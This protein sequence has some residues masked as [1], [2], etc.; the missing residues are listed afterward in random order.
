MKLAS[1][2]MASSA[3]ISKSALPSD[4]STVS[5]ATSLKSAGVTEFSDK[6]VAAHD[7]SAQLAP[8]KMHP[9]NAYTNDDFFGTEGK[10]HLYA[11]GGYDRLVGNGG[12]DYLFAGDNNGDWRGTGNESGRAAILEG[13]ADN[14]LMQVWADKG[15]FFLDTGDGRDHVLISNDASYVK[16]NNYDSTDAGDTFEFNATFSGKA[17]IWSFDENDTLMFN[18]VNSG[19]GPG[20]HWDISY[21]AQTYDTTFFNPATQG[22]IVLHGV[23]ADRFDTAVHFGPTDQL[24]YGGWMYY[25]EFPM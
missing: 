6:A 21:D 18:T 14:D 25:I 16:I 2:K 8:T 4:H 12:D 11:D 13:G 20:T 22:E 1:T 5:T 15:A 19:S 9:I 23:E 24:P 3:A 10:D 17:D 7:F